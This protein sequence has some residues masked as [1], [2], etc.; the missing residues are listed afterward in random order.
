VIVAAQY[1]SPAVRRLLAAL[2]DHYVSTYGAHDL[3]D[4]DPAEYA[5][6]EGGCLVGFENGKPV[7]VGC[8][9]RHGPDVCELRRFYVVP[10]ARGRRGARRMLDAVLT[11]ARAAGYERAVCATAAGRGLTG[12]EVRPIAPFGSHTDSPGVGCYEIRLFSSD[13]I[14]A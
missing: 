1:D 7:A 3:D 14:A 4:D 11:A 9:R 13:A 12:L 8:W 6:P 5:A 10:S 2:A